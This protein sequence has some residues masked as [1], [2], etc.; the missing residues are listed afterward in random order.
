MYPAL[1]QA[2]DQPLSGFRLLR[3]VIEPDKGLASGRVSRGCLPIPP[4][5]ARYRICN[6][7]ALVR[8]VLLDDADNFE[9]GEVVRRAL[10]PALG[11]SILIAD[12]ARWRWQRRAVAPI[13]HQKTITNFLP[14]MIADATYARSLARLRSRDR[15]RRFPRNDANNIR[16]HLEYHV[17]WPQQPRR[18]THKAIHHRLS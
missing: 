16:Y 14:A 7:P 18:G 10:S 11:D 5:R 13:F 17:A 15:V 8:T 3:T 9:K 6:A 2:P 4:V 1:I 12:G